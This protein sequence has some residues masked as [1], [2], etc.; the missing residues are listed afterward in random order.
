[1]SDS[2]NEIDLK[3]LVTPY[4]SVHVVT[5]DAL[6]EASLY[7]IANESSTVMGALDRDAVKMLIDPVMGQLK[8]TDYAGPDPSIAYQEVEAGE[9]N[10]L[11]VSCSVQVMD[12][13]LKLPKTGPIIF[14][15]PRDCMHYQALLKYAGA[16]LI[17]F[18]CYP[19]D[20]IIA[21]AGIFFVDELIGRNQP[22]FAKYA[23]LHAKDGL[24]DTAAPYQVGKF[25][26]EVMKVYGDCSV[27]DIK[28]GN[29]STGS[30][31]H[32]MLAV[33]KFSS[34]GEAFPLKFWPRMFGTVEYVK[35]MK[36]MTEAVSGEGDAAADDGAGHVSKKRT[37]MEPT[38]NLIAKKDPKNPT[39]DLIKETLV[40]SKKRG[41]MNVTIL[42][43]DF[44]HAC[45]HAFQHKAKKLDSAGKCIKMVERLEQANRRKRPQ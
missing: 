23:G 14:V 45:G 39:E 1:M 10:V 2:E 26:W 28:S 34:G 21:N 11:I 3:S 25:S 40:M 18:T 20:L 32:A 17:R 16:T 5:G 6:H 12:E 9:K 30:T 35:E 33:I 42:G 38:G 44:C 15:H 41:K 7:C 27:G 19:T 8:M 37:V 31:A 29:K 24:I 4:S 13:I 22:A 43:C 36:E